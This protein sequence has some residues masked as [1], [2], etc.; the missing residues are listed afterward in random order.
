MAVE[1][2]RLRERR[3]AHVRMQPGR[4]EERQ[5][6]GEL[7]VDV[8]PTRRDRL[9]AAGALGLAGREAEQPAVDPAL[10]ARR[11]GVDAGILDAGEQR[12]VERRGSRRAGRAHATGSARSASARAAISRAK[13]RK[14]S[15]PFEA[16]IEDDARHAVARRFGEADVARDHGVEDLVAE[17]RLELLADL[18]LQRDAGVEHDAQ[19][20]DH[21]ERRVEVGV[22]LLDRVDQVREAFEGEVLALHRHDDAVRARQAVQGQQAEAGRAVDEHEVVVGGGGGERAAQALVAPLEPDQLHLGAGQ[23]AVRADDVVAALRARLARLGDRRVLEQ[24]VVDAQVEGALVDAGAHGRVAL[25]IE[26]D[27]QGAP[28]ELGET[29]GQVHGGRGLADAALLVGDAEDSHR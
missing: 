15:A 10:L 27:D 23:L 13:S 7:G 20:A 1:P 22:H 29:G 2:G 12:L 24:D 19:D 26:V 3:D 17:V 25:R 4:G 21:L 14:A 6:Q 16:G 18:R 9:D 8:E 5:A 28:A 11:A